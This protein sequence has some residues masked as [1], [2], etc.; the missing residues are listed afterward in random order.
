MYELVQLYHNC[1]YHKNYNNF[2]LYRDSKVIKLSPSIEKHPPSL[3]NIKFKA[4]L[5]PYILFIYDTVHK[6]LYKNVV[7]FKDKIYISI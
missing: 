1:I 7:R 3:R 6:M 5:L 4:Y 2:D